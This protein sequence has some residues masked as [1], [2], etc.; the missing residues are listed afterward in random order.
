MQVCSTAH[1]V[2]APTLVPRET[3][4]SPNAHMGVQEKTQSRC[5]EGSGTLISSTRMRTRQQLMTT[6]VEAPHRTS[7]TKSGLR[8]WDTATYQQILLLMGL[9]RVEALVAVLLQGSTQQVY[10]KNCHNG[11]VHVT[12][13]IKQSMRYLKDN[14]SQ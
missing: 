11:Q 5:A 14:K 7:T 12:N 10:Y 3:A 1:S 6:D 9:A 2:S 13:Y 4:M 8:T